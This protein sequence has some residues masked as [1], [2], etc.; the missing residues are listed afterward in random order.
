[1][2]FRRASGPLKI[3]LKQASEA[4]LKRCLGVTQIWRIIP[5]K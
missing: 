4:L 5:E 3:P 2:V 1:V